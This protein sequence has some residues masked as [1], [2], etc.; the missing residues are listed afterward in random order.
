[1]K[2]IILFL[3]AL[4][5]FV[6]IFTIQITSNVVR[7]TTYISV[8][9]VSF[10]QNFQQ[11]I[12]SDQNNVE[13]EFPARVSPMTATDKQVEYLTSDKDIATVNK[14]GLIVFKNFGY[15]R[16]TARSVVAKTIY[17]ECLFHITDDKAHI[18]NFTNVDPSFQ[19]T[20]GEV[21]YLKTQIIP[22]EALD[23]NVTFTS[24]DES[25][26]KVAADGQLTAIEG[27][28]ATIT[29]STANGVTNQV[30]V[31]VFVPVSNITVSSTNIV[32][33][34]NNLIFPEIK[35]EPANAT[36]KNVTYTTSN[37][38]L[39]LINSQ[40]EITLKEKGLVVFTATSVD[41]SHKAT[42]S[43]N[44]TG[45]YVTHAD[46]SEQYE[47]KTLELNFEQ[48]KLIPITYQAYPADYKLSHF[49][50][51]WW[52]S[53]NENVVK[54]NGE[55]IIIVGGGV[56]ELC[57]N[58]LVDKD[59][60]IK[61]KTTIK[62]NRA[63]ATINIFDLGNDDLGDIAD[64]EIIVTNS[65][66]T[67]IH[68]QVLTND[69]TTDHTDVVTVSTQVGNA[70]CNN[71]ICYLQLDEAKAQS[72]NLTITAGAV[73][74]TVT[75]KYVLD[76]ATNLYVQ[77]GDNVQLESGS[78]Y[79]LWVNNTVLD[80]ACQDLDI[81]AINNDKSLTAK[82]GGLTQL[83]AQSDIV[84]NVEVIRN[85][86]DI[87]LN[88]APIN[89]NSIII[90]KSTYSLKT[91][92][93]P[94]DATNKQIAYSSKNTS[95]ATVTS[96][97]VVEFIKA[98]SA[99]ITLSIKK[100]P[101]KAELVTREITITS[102]MGNV[103]S[104]ELV[105]NSDILLTDIGETGEICIADAFL[106]AD[107]ELNTNHV[108]FSSS[109]PSI[110]TVEKKIID[111]KVYGII[112][113]V[114]GGEATIYARMGDVQK[115]VKVIVNVL[116]K[117]LSMQYLNGGMFKDWEDSQTV[118]SII[119]PTIQLGVKFYPQN[120][121]NKEVAYAIVEGTSA[122]VSE[123]GLVTFSEI[124]TVKVR[125]IAIDS[126]VFV[127][128]L[129]QRQ[130][131]SIYIYQGENDVTNTNVLVQR[132]DANPQFRA[133]FEMPNTEGKL[134]DSADYSQ[135]EIVSSDDAI[136]INSDNEGLFTV[137]KPDPLNKTIKLTLEFNYQDYK[138]QVYVKLLA[139]DD[140][141]IVQNIN[142]RVVV[143]D[144]STDYTYG[145]EQKHVFGTHS[146]VLANGSTQKTNQSLLDVDYLA[147]PSTNTDTINWSFGQG[148]SMVNYQNG[149]LNFILDNMQDG[150]NIIEIKIHDEQTYELS[151][152]KAS[153]TMI[154][155]KNAINA[156]DSETYAYAA[157]ESERGWQ[158]VIHANLGTAEDDD[159]IRPYAELSNSSYKELHSTIYGN[160]Y[161]LNLHNTTATAYD[162]QGGARNIKLKQYNDTVNVSSYTKTFAARTDVTYAY[163][164]FTNAD[165]GM[166][167]DQQLVTIYYY[168]CL[169]T[170]TNK[171]GIQL[172]KNDKT[173]GDVTVF[174]ED[175]VFNNVGPCAVDFQ[176]GT[177]YIKGKFE[178]Y[179]FKTAAD[180]SGL[181][182]LAI[183]AAFRSNEFKQYVDK[184]GT[185]VANVGIVS[186]SAL[187][188][189]KSE[190]YFYNEAT[191]GY[192][193]TDNITGR[194]LLRVP[195]KTLGKHVLNLW[196]E[197]IYDTNGN[198]IDGVITKTS[199]VDYTIL[200]R[201]PTYLESL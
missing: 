169:F 28:T 74:K 42:Y 30:E 80:W 85:V 130:L 21:I 192:E 133:K 89:Q 154:V 71:N 115:T 10:G 66:L 122:T 53:S 170:K 72:F 201:D 160:G 18:I 87:Y 84:I 172:G 129:L 46:I 141:D 196:L 140:I 157:T 22:Q 150:E 145:Y 75:I 11:I 176:Q 118:S 162:L 67:E 93:Y 131:A 81:L 60:V 54:I 144:N 108:S 148:A 163:V 182:S 16:I 76:N 153:Y 171:C 47:D 73:S 4:I 94:Q 103:T 142:G 189:P 45:G 24:S 180:F 167:I 64:D 38:E 194:N 124:G 56:S 99:T 77:N 112:T 91:S 110:A 57:L 23:K 165:K 127:D 107:Y 151:D 61:S 175:C 185:P 90:S 36:N 44:Y 132:T 125:A 39:G 191:G 136:T 33:A 86:D 195:G 82:Q 3:V 120:T 181:Q 111:N 55:E 147:Y 173:N 164:H 65:L 200:Y 40:G 13:L 12:K 134:L 31:F 34:T 70:S 25:V 68:F 32:T 15:V 116:S 79:V 2:K 105:D 166:W 49:T 187:G 183:S 156:Y 174:F 51:V 48:N 52:E 137:V 179:N 193:Q 159:G 58:A 5:P 59:V 27:G 6:L 9:K 143:L 149:V 199:Q 178:V 88:N 146:Y 14:D 101:N 97:G 198:P 117:Q 102:T 43:V 100:H 119:N 128:V 95:V 17:D 69:S 92:V 114:D 184:T 109:N 138:T 123:T 78:T 83:T 126:G 106:P 63:A 155:I 104:F 7:T 186:Y 190:V 96:D 113:G 29:V 152:V 37:Q 168:K 20:K 135:I 50:N 139:L 1:M 19:L 197:K 41:G 188:T 8:E 121:T 98:G 158:I 62:V 35:F 177:I 161:T 26:A